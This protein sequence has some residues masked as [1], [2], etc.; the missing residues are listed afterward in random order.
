MQRSLSRFMFVIKWQTMG[1]RHAV[2]CCR[3]Y[4]A[5]HG[6]ERIEYEEDAYGNTVGRIRN[7]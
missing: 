7:S 1:F 5:M 4:P 6:P 2:P 3:A